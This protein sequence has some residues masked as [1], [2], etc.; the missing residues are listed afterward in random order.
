MHFS[1]SAATEVAEDW[2]QVRLAVQREGA[3]A[4]SVQS[5]LALLLEAAIATAMPQHK[6][7]S[8]EVSTGPIHVSPRFDRDGKSNGWVG[9]AQLVLQG[10]DAAQI[11]ALAGRVRE[12][13]VASID[14]RLSPELQKQVGSRLQ[15]EAIDSFKNKAQTLTRHWGM[16]RYT[17]KD[18]R[19][20]S[21]GSEDD[22]APL[23]SRMQMENS[24]NRVPS[25]AGKARVVVN[26]SGTV[27][28]H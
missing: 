15:A 21:G 22:A 14:W 28:M 27:Q 8:L 1:E 10:R 13:T 23:M 24:A 17:L 11:L 18:V 26:V 12:F 16:S 3:Q 19:V 7:A 4:P 6:P 25:V 5:Q 9:S 2:L 20:S